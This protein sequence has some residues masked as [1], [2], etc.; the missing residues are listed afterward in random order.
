MGHVAKT[1]A[2][3]KGMV[4]QITSQYPRCEF[5]RAFDA[6]VIS[7]YPEEQE[8]LIGFMYMRVLEIRT[9]PLV[10]DIKNQEL[11]KKAPLASR[12][13]SLFFSIHLFREQMFSMSEHLEYY[14][15][16]FLK[17]NRLDCCEQSVYKQHGFGPN[18]SAIKDSFLSFLC[19]Q[20]A[21]HPNALTNND[22]WIKNVY[23]N[24]ANIK[25]MTICWNKFNLFRE[26]P[27]L[28]QIIKIDMI[29]DGLKEFFLDKEHE[30]D[31]HDNYKYAVSFEKLLKVFPN[32]EEVHYINNYKFDNDALQKL[33]NILGEIEIQTKHHDVVVTKI[34]KKR[35][36]SD[37]ESKEMEKTDLIIPKVYTHNLK[38]IVFLYYDFEDAFDQNNN[39]LGY[40]QNGDRFFHPNG[41]DDEKMKS[42]N[43]Y[44]W[45][46]KHS[47]NGKTGYKI[48]IY[49]KDEK[50]EYGQRLNRLKK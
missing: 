9:R 30:K 31:I 32:V 34:Q 8:Y 4:L 50:E 2:T 1:F 47:E 40:P 48:R 13:R 41:L 10:N 27:N 33:L 5:C 39:V 42:L 49:K 19:C 17:C 14:L 37:N 7:D 21:H 15:I 3:A 23:N 45:I 43:K 11:W 28:K 46:L 38:K 22:D 35:K 29:S 44:G 20:V 24:V 25:V 26:Q 18:D 36:N 12:V 6:S 16:E